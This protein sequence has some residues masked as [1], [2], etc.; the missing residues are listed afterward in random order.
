MGR[1]GNLCAELRRGKIKMDDVL[2]RAD[3]DFQDP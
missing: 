1:E 2:S 3:Q